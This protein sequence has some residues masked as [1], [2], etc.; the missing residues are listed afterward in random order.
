MQSET[1][2]CAWIPTMFVWRLCINKLPYAA[3]GSTIE[4]TFFFVNFLLLTQKF[5]DRLN[6][7][8]VYRKSVNKFNKF[9]FVVGI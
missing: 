5:K 4:Y 7:C 8:L 1:V 2:A 9:S 6:T 3:V